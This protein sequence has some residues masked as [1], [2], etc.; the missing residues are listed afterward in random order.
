M[1]ATHKLIA[2]MQKIIKNGGR[3]SATLGTQPLGES[4]M[5][6]NWEKPGCCKGSKG[7]FANAGHAEQFFKL[8]KNPL[9]L[10][11]YLGKYSFQQFHCISSAS[12]VSLTVRYESLAFQDF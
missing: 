1:L 3:V 11:A 2:R 12:V 10:A 9:C 4:P 5:L 7:T 6:A 8:S